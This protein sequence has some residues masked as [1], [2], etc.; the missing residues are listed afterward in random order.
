MKE[1]PI[2]YDVASCLR[3]SF[4]VPENAVVIFFD[5]NP[6]MNNL[7]HI[8]IFVAVPPKE[9][10]EGVQDVIMK[11]SLRYWTASES[12]LKNKEI[13][14]PSFG[15]FFVMKVVS[16]NAKLSL[17]LGTNS[18]SDIVIPKMFFRANMRSF[19]RIKGKL[20][21]NSPILELPP[22]ISMEFA[23]PSMDISSNLIDL[24]TSGS[25]TSLTRFEEPFPAAC[26]YEAGLSVGLLKTID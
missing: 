2:P 1:N 4:D 15:I 13:I 8:V 23:G 18:A 26:E 14:S 19:M 12:T 22:C 6:G 25:S 17:I 11:S 16:S 10:V 3:A 20:R 7:P 24:T 5:S 9:L 21:P